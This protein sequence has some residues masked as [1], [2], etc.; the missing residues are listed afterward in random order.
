M[1]IEIANFKTDRSHGRKVFYWSSLLIHLRL[2]TIVDPR[3]KL[4]REELCMIKIYDNLIFSN[5]LCP[6]S[7]LKF[8]WV[9]KNFQELYD[10]TNN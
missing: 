10:V 8:P 3:L 5:A 4:D 1:N 7:C 2:V 9:G 6:S